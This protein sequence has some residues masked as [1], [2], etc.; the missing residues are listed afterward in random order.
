MHYHMKAL[1]FCWNPFLCLRW[2][3]N[4]TGLEETKAMTLKKSHDETVL[5]APA[6]LQQL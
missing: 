1:V 4:E 3:L 5:S 6:S 2:D